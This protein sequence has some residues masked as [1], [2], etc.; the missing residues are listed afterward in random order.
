MNDIVF[1]GKTTIID[2]LVN[3]T[4]FSCGNCFLVG[5]MGIP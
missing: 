4:N 3:M 1:F 2:L 5:R